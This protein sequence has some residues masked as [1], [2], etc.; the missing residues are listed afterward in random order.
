MKPVFFNFIKQHFFMTIILSVLILSSCR[1]FEK[2]RDDGAKLLDIVFKG[3]L[4]NPAWSPDGNYI[5]FTKFKKYNEEPAAIIKLDLSNN[6]T[7]TLVSDGS[8]NVNLP[9]SCWND[10]LNKIVFSSSREPHDEIYMIDENGTSGTE[11]QVTSRTD[12]MAYEPSFSPDGQ[13][14]VFES[15]YLEQ[16]GSGVITKYKLDGSSGYVALTTEGEDCRQPNWSPTN[17]YIVYQ[18]YTSDSWQLWLIKPDGTDNKQLTSGTGEKTDASF[19]PDGNWLVYSSNEADE[20][21]ANLFIISVNGGSSIR[22]T[23]YK[24]YDGA[25]SWSPDGNYIVFESRFKDPDGTKG[26]KL[27]KIS[28]PAH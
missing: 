16:E 4:Q 27:Y 24:G 1:K 10:S 8:G 5:V 2:E 12:K 25:P 21:Y 11:T 9:G 17:N 13:W 28:V 14:V 20:D 6:S 7:T 26:T 15:H 23:N 22:A 19:S 18:R 3:S